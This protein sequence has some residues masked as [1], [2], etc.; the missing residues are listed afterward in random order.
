MLL[1][2]TPL[3]EP[4]YRRWGILLFILC[5]HVTVFWIGRT[6][7]NQHQIK[8]MQYLSLFNVQKIENLKPKTVLPKVSTKANS[9]LKADVKK[10]SNAEANANSPEAN[11][12]LTLPSTPS[13]DVSTR[14]NLDMLR[15]QAVQIE[16]TRVKS[17]IEKMNDGKKLDLSLEATFD[18][19]VN[20][21]ELP[22]CRRVLLG[23]SMPERMRIIQDHSKKMFCRSSM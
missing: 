21:V 12:N 22:E 5:L 3:Q 6:A 20:R 9:E 17:D 14:L 11:K 16:R 10:M 2:H 19:E 8:A 15:G 7:G 1:S 23:K 18:R 13:A 4:G